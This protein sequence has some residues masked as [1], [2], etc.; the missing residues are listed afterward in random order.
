MALDTH[1]TRIGFIGLGLMGRWMAEHIRTA[2]Y[3]MHVFNRTKHK[4]DPLIEQGAV[5]HETPA[6]LA[7]ESDA[8]FTIIGY[9]GDVEEIYL[10][11]SGLIASCRPGTYLVDMT[12]SE[13]HLAV[14]IFEAAKAKD[15]HALDAP[16]SGGVKGAREAALTIMVGGE[17]ADFEAVVPVLRHM[18]TSVVHQG[19]AGSGQ[20][21]KACNQIINANTIMGISEA[22]AYAHR[23]GLDIDAVLRSV[24]AGSA[25]SFHLS[26][27]APKMAAGDFRPGFKLEHM[28]KDLEIAVRGAEALKLALQGTEVAL[29]NYRHLDSQGG[30]QEGIQALYKIYRDG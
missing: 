9:P 12:T 16:V 1:T 3:A 22:L 4:A 23:A 19:G 2:G 10:G 26:N 15:L 5:W 30:A 6:S 25:A 17:K 13:P 18:G 11:P 28:I 24:G 14:R 20:H 21:T 7:R 27:T 29:R 8:I